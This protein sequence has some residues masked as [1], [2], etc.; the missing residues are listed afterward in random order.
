VDWLSSRRGFSQIGLQVKEQSN[1]N[2]WE[3]RYVFGKI[4]EA[5]VKVWQFSLFSLKYGDF[6]P[7]LFQ[8]GT[9]AGFAA[10]FLCRQG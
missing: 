6:V 2:F 4:L 7:F 1:N 3:P 9:I 8:K 10:C 5:M